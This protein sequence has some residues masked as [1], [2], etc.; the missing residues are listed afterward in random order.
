MLKM[1]LR[2]DRRRFVRSVS[3]VAIAA[4]LSALLLLGPIHNHHDAKYHR[5]CAACLH[6][7]SFFSLVHQV[8]L[9]NG[10]ALVGTL[11]MVG[12]S[13]LLFTHPIGLLSIRSPPSY[14]S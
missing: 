12:M 9:P 5:D 11:L 7:S 6:Q 10:V 2:A 14:W 3:W 4:L 1:K 8:V 13:L